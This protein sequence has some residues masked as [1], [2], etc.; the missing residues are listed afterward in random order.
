MSVLASISGLL[1]LITVIGSI[2]G[3]FTINKRLKDIYK[4]ATTSKGILSEMYIEEDL[5]AIKT[6][7]DFMLIA[8]VVG[9]LFLITLCLT[10]YDHDQSYN[11]KP[12]ISTTY[13]FD[14]DVITKT[15][16]KCYP[17]K[18]DIDTCYVITTE[19]KP[20]EALFND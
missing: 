6:E 5:R 9:I 14:N 1:F 19:S 20:A 16:S 7:N 15:V 2:F 11:E 13:S 18:W 3:L 4:L 12:Y 8:L 17:K 10:I